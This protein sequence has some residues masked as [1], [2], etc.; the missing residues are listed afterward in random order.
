MSKCRL[1]AKIGSSLVAMYIAAAVPGI[2]VTTQSDGTGG[3]D[4]TTPPTTTTTNTTDGHEW[5]D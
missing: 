1:L 2:S 5:D 4:P 3:T